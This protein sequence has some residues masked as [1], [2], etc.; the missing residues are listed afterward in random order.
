MPAHAGIQHRERGAVEKHLSR[1]A[2]W[3][4]AFA[5]M[6]H[7]R[8]ALGWIDRYETYVGSHGK[9]LRLWL[10]ALRRFNRRGHK[11]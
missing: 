10:P 6:T 9:A 2:L 8:M 5:G 11:A 3:I 4:P 7:C 1:R